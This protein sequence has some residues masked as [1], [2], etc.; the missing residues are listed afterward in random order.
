MLQD[1]LG[2]KIGSDLFELQSHYLEGQNDQTQNTPSN[3]WSWCTCPAS[4]PLHNKQTDASLNEHHARSMLHLVSLLVT[5][6][7]PHFHV[8]SPPPLTPPHLFSEQVF[9]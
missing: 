6:T 2:Q 7:F 3:V 4:T 1:Y 9:T 8:S 5:E